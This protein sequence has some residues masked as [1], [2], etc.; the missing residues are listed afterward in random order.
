[1]HEG[2]YQAA[3]RSYWVS[4]RLVGR[5]G[6]ARRAQDELSLGYLLELMEDVQADIAARLDDA[7]NVL[8]TETLRPSPAQATRFAPVNFADVRCSV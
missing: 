8:V 5:I 4:P 7:V 2:I 6:D 3:A 1:M